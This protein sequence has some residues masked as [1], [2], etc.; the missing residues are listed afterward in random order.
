LS[1]SV[2]ITPAAMA[3]KN[4][5]ATAARHASNA[6]VFIFRAGSAGGSFLVNAVFPASVHQ[7]CSAGALS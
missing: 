5:V 4:I 2:A 3:P 7:Q 6:I 1:I